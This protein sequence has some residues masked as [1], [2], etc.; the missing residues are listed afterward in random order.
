MRHQSRKLSAAGLALYSLLLTS[1]CS[2]SRHEASEVYYLVA[3]NIKIPYWQSAFAGLQRATSEL[4]V[5]A[6]MVGPDSYSPILQ[7]DHF[8]RVLAEKPA[9]IMISAADPELMKP[10][11]DAAVAAGIPV[12]TMDSDV[13]GSRRLFF[14]GTNNFQAGL[15]GGR[16]LAQKLNRKGQ[17][18]V[19]TI[20]TQANLV[21][22]LRGYEEA[23]APTEI[24]V[25]Q[26]IDIRG[27]PTV[28]FD[29]TMEII[30]KSKLN[31]DAFV[32]L[33]A[34]AGKEVAEVLERRK[35][36]GTTVIAMDT[37]KETLDW[38]E[39]GRIAATIAQ[40][41]FT[42][43]YV[44]LR[45]LDNMHHYKP[46]KLD[47]DWSQDLQATVP[48]VVDTGASLIDKTNV[49]AMRKSSATHLA[50]LLGWVRPWLGQPPAYR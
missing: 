42:M 4:G 6:E 48:A 8:K 27:D 45:M 19:Y 43:A 47:T 18:I 10:E 5:R 32:C 14:I 16:V 28:A 31:I 24:K 17:V 46:G 38:I 36:E 34:T 9:G 25:V 44:G 50:E 1:G 22:R 20:P 49:D 35:A 11:I 2:K 3:S 39:K 23:L 29:R 33:E 7:R 13:P 12:I 37:D 41:P 30:E 26:T 40:K 21:E 15:M